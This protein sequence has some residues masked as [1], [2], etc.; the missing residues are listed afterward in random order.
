MFAPGGA[1]EGANIKNKADAEIDRILKEQYE[2]GMKLLTE[3]MDLLDL[4]A[5]TL[6]EEEK[7][8][9]NQLLA[10]IKDIKPNL[11]SEKAIAAVAEVVKPASNSQ[12]TPA[13]ATGA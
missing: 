8:N 11:V 3:N 12:P 5:K 10:L 2:R 13:P 9:G 4:I 7:I 1:S 6:I